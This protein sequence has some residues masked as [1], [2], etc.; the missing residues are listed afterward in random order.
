MLSLK[1]GNETIDTNGLM[2]KTET[3]TQKPNSWLPKGK[4]GTGKLGVQG[5]QIQTN[6][7]KIYKQQGPIV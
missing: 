6:I 1:R 4:G 3:Q 2:Y 7:Y 5:W